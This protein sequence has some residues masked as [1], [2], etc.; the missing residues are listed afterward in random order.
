MDDTNVRSFK[1][2]GVFMNGTNEWD[3]V[4]TIL[5]NVLNGEDAEKLVYALKTSMEHDFNKILNEFAKKINEP[6]EI[7]LVGN[8]P[9]FMREL[10]QHLENQTLLVVYAL[11]ELWKKPEK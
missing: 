3:T 4:E 1:V 8:D 5:N 7:L 10:L 6:V 11:Q 2:G 9:K